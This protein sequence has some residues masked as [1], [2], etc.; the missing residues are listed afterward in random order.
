MET[1]STSTSLTTLALPWWR[2]KR[3]KEKKCC[4][5]WGSRLHQTDENLI[6]Q[7]DDKHFWSSKKIRCENQTNRNTGGAGLIVTAS[8]SLHI[9]K[10]LLHPEAQRGP[11]IWSSGPTGPIKKGKV[12]PPQI[13]IKTLLCPTT[14]EC[15][16]CLSVDT[17]SHTALTFFMIRIN[18]SW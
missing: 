10:F 9:Q 5:F 17:V 6:Y 8:L 1:F 12:L 13:P 3:N 7:N 14:R 2:G 4:N 11:N 16:V 15:S 18:T